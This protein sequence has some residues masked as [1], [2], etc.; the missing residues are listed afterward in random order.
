MRESRLMERPDTTVLP[1]IRESLLA[2]PEL[3]PASS[4][5]RPV[6]SL[7]ISSCFFST[8]SS[9]LEKFWVLVCFV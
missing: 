1:S 9:L 6:R 3:T 5:L 7:N 4:D 2:I 8:F